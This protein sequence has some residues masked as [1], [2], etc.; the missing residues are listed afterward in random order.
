MKNRYPLHQSPLYC[1]HSRRRL[2]SEVI[3]MPLSRLESLAGQADNYR[4]ATRYTGSKQRTVRVPKPPLRDVQG[5]IGDL[6]NRIELA[7]YMHSGCRGRSY[8]SNALAH[9]GAPWV[10]KLDIQ[11]FYP[12]VTRDRVW[13]FFVDTMKCAPDVAALLAS[14]CTYQGS[15]PIGSRVSQVLAFHVVRP[16]LDELQA[17]ARSRGAVFTCYVDDLTFSGRDIDAS[18]KE[19]A[20]AI[21]CRHGFTPHDSRRHGPGEERRVTGVVLGSEG[22]RVPDRNLEQIQ[23]TR[24]TLA[25]AHDDVARLLGLSRLAGQLAAAA[26]IEERFKVELLSLQPE[27]RLLNSRLNRVSALSAEAG[28]QRR[29]FK[30]RPQRLSYGSSGQT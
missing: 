14:I 19:Q 9:A 1:L 29:T 24:A 8:V 23:A 27:L 10:A 22:P 17:F 2:A 20:E 6:L 7:P 30:L 13:H 3:G 5:R 12:S 15:V 11:R 28:K 25:H 26:A 4:P 18:F 21:V 16:M